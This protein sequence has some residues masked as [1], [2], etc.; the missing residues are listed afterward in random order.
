MV[1]NSPI[2]TITSI[3]SIQINSFPENSEKKFGSVRYLNL[4]SIWGGS[5][6]LIFIW[7]LTNCIMLK[8]SILGSI[9]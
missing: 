7:I 6:N 9:I 8:K 5:F 1:K 3:F 2:G 4:T